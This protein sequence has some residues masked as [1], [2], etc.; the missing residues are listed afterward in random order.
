MFQDLAKTVHM[1]I[2]NQIP[3]FRKLEFL[4]FQRVRER[5]K[6]KATRQREI[7]EVRQSPKSVEE[8]GVGRVVGRVHVAFN[9]DVKGF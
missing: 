6:R 1:A 7:F 9:Q 2:E 8:I 5:T 4:S 3:K